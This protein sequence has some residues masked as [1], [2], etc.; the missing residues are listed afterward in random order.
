MDCN[1]FINY[2]LEKQRMTNGCSINCEKCALGQMASKYEI[3]CK[4]LELFSPTMALRMVQNWSNQ[5]EV[6]TNLEIV[7]KQFP[8]I[9]I[10]EN[11]GVPY[12]CVRSLGLKGK[13][14]C[15]MTGT[16]GL[17][18]NSNYCRECWNMPCE[19]KENEKDKSK[20]G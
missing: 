1:S 3:G 18:N 20:K 8:N 6:E 15:K 14:Y 13:E 11:D 17:C 7:L 9:V 10:N 12:I 4:A 19:V 16:E 5:H 2:Q